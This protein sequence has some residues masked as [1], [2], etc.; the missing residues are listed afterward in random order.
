[1]PVHL[2][3]ELLLACCFLAYG[4]VVRASAPVRPEVTELLQQLQA[5]ETTDRAA[6][7]LLKLAKGDVGVRRVL[8]ERLP[9]IIAKG[10]PP[11]PW[12]NHVW[13][14]AVSLSGELKIKEACEALAKW[15]HT[16]GGP[17]AGEGGMGVHM[18]LENKPAAKALAQIGDPALPVVAPVL[19]RDNDRERWDAVYILNLIGSPAAIKLLREH[20]SSEPNPHLRELIQRILGIQ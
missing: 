10:Q 20:V 13:F 2:K 15:M 18:R 17:S 11:D 14:N 9:G 8:A 1:M 19:N 7:E 16:E 4:G 12:V 6:P 5:P 3:W